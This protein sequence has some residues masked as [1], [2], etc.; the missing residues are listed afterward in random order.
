MPLLPHKLATWLNQQKGGKRKEDR[1]GIM[2][3]TVM[4]MRLGVMAWT[5]GEDNKDDYNRNKYS[6]NK[7]AKNKCVP[8]ASPRM[9]LALLR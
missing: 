2:K 5:D 1:R 9:M 7:R 3:R 8:L 6:N 4:T